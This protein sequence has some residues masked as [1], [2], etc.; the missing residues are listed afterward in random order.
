MSPRLPPAVARALTVLRWSAADAR[1]VLDA[2]TASGLSRADF[3]RAHGVSTQRL[4]VWQRRL[5]ARTPAPAPAPGPP[6]RFVEV[7]GAPPT[8]SPPARIEVGWPGGPVVRFA[9]P[10]DEASLRLVL[11]VLREMGPC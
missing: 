9:A 7:H 11:R 6:L 5:A 2:V 1:L 10:L 8:A 3:A 4:Y